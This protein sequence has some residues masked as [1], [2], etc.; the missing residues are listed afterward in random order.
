MANGTSF[1]TQGFE[2]IATYGTYWCDRSLLLLFT[3]GIDPHMSMHLSD[4]T[5]ASFPGYARIEIAT[6]P[7]SPVWN[8]ILLFAEADYGVLTFTLS[9]DVSPVSIYGIGVLSEALI[10]RWAYMQP[11]P[12]A[13]VQHAGDTVNVHL[14]LD[15]ASQQA[16]VP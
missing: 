14:V 9:A 16:L 13:T 8:P 3:D 2:D 10:F 15:W 4:F 1:T 11:T 12:Y 7:V 5:E 6:G